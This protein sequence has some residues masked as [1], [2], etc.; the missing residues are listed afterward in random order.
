[1]TEKKTSVIDGTEYEEMGPYCQLCR[2]HMGEYYYGGGN[3]GKDP[4]DAPLMFLN[5]HGYES[6]GDNT[7]PE[8]GT[9]YYYE[10][11]NMIELTDEDIRALLALRQKG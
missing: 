5:P 4:K 11:G 9:K 1:M 7:C 10:E 2:A 6:Y 3:R 8:C